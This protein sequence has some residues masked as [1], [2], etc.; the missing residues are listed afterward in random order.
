MRSGRRAGIA[1]M[2]TCCSISSS[3]LTSPAWVSWKCSASGRACS[4]TPRRSELNADTV[5]I[6]SRRSS[7]FSRI[8]DVS[9]CWA[10][11]RNTFFAVDRTSRTRPFWL[12]ISSFSALCSFSWTLMT[13]GSELGGSASRIW[14][15]TSR[16]HSSSSSMSPI[17][18]SDR[19]LESWMRSPLRWI[20]SAIASNLR[21]SRVT[22]PS[23]VEAPSPGDIWHSCGPTKLMLSNTGRNSW[24]SCSSRWISS[25]RG[26]AHCNWASAPI[27][28]STR[29]LWLLWN[30]WTNGNAS[31]ACL[32]RSAPRV[33]RS[34]NRRWSKSSLSFNCN[35]SSFEMCFISSRPLS[36]VP[37]TWLW[38]L[39]ISSVK[40]A[41]SSICSS[42]LSVCTARTLYF[43]RRCSI[44]SIQA[45]RSWY[46]ST[47]WRRPARDCWS[48]WPTFSEAPTKAA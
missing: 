7:I 6:V 37:S 43:A 44:P 34:L 19:C 28:Q 17:T 16:N 48:S 27:I 8:V 42:S 47:R 21:L 5:S 25:S 20:C 31:W 24:I 22:R 30:C 11:S 40:S 45:C 41:R 33:V 4:N 3:Q 13:S 10:D 1:S 23:M 15:S 18:S 38:W 9:S 39:A 2:A 29:R 46:V 32:S 26:S 12:E 14:L 36:T 35:A